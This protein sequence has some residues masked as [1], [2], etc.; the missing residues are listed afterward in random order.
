MFYLRR[1]NYNL[2]KTEMFSASSSLRITAV[3]C[4]FLIELCLIILVN[5]LHHFASTGSIL[6]KTKKN[7]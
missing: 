3:L 6:T 5:N 7:T 4:F 1:V 2:S